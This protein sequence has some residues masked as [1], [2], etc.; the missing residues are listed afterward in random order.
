VVDD[1][2]R[3]VELR[4]PQAPGATAPPQDGGGA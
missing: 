1:L 3:F 2:L 4:V